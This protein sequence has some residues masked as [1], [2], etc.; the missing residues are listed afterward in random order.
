MNN[1]RW[2]T[3][4][5][6]T[7]SNLWKW[8][9]LLIIG[10][11]IFAPLSCR[12]SQVQQNGNSSLTRDTDRGSSAGHVDR[13]DHQFWRNQWEEKN[14]VP[15]EKKLENKFP[16]VLLYRYISDPDSSYNFPFSVANFESKS[17]VYTQKHVF[18]SCFYCCSLWRKSFV[19]SPL[20]L[21]SQFYWGIEPFLDWC[22]PFELLKY[23]SW[24]VSVSA[25]KQHCWNDGRSSSIS[26]T[27]N[28]QRWSKE[29]L[30]A[31]AILLRHYSILQDVEI[32]RCHFPS[33]TKGSKTCNIHIFSF[34]LT[35]LS[36][37]LSAHR[38]LRSSWF[39]PFLQHFFLIKLYD[40][41]KHSFPCLFCL[42]SL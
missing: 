12:S 7:V 17:L 8:L 25:T 18:D 9:L 26:N 23:L 39:M 13:N 40:I 11:R 30:S 29:N 4:K 37:T 21:L 5:E 20:L 1:R 10:Q 32:L 38:Q 41:W 14:R 35:L 22:Y 2:R 6:M 36:E 28:L 24:S 16:M 27:S 34:C 33:L 19:P 42:M 15:I 3:S 31:I